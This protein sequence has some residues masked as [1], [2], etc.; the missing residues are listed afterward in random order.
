M[1]V[2][3]INLFNKFIVA[4]IS[5]GILPLLFISFYSG[6]LFRR[7]TYTLI[8]DNYQQAALYGVRNLD[9]LIEKYNTISKLL[10]SYN[11]DKN[12]II[13]RA[14]G[15]GLARVLNDTKAD[16]PGQIK[17]HNDIIS[18]LYLIH[19]SDTYITNVVFA[20][21]DGTYYA[22]GQNNRPF[23]DE[24]VFLNSMN[25]KQIPLKANQL[26]VIPTHQDNYF[27]KSNNQVFTIG[28]NYIDL[29]YHLGVDRIIG[30]LYIDINIKCIDDIF[31]QLDIYHSGSIA[32]FDS[33][34]NL[35]YGNLIYYNHLINGSGS[36]EITQHCDNIPWRIVLT[37]DIERA[38]HNVVSI[39]RWISI[40]V[41]LVLTALLL[42]SV[43]YS[44][45]FSNPI[46][47]LLEGMKKV[48]AGDFTIHVKIKAHDEIGEL[49]EGFYQMTARLKSYIQTS[50]LAQIRQKEAELS[51]LKAKIK[52][53]FLYNS[54]ELIR[55][56]AI[57]HND[58]ST[59]ELVFLLAGQIRAS[60]EHLNET[61]NLSQELDMIRGYFA[62]IDLRYNHNIAWDISCDPSLNRVRVLSLMLQPIIE[63]AVIHGIKPRG[64]GH[65]RI[66]IEKQGDNLII[67]VTDD[68][69]GMDEEMVKKIKMHLQKEYREEDR[70]EDSIGLKNVHDRLRYKYGASYGV[71][72]FSV[73]ESGTTIIIT[74]PFIQS[75]GS[76]V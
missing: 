23:A 65:I 34:N 56:N 3:R 54:L 10:Y 28:R 72:I 48:E 69:V 40:I 51:S 1:G 17:R 59:A 55:M 68:G 49:A 29:S 76:D 19:T 73:P 50:F 70:D 43:F 74:L 9:S 4:F 36:L 27:Q 30:T 7:E 39:I 14:D 41:V 37:A 63:N 61:V 31:K 53:H 47:N 35:I 42:V 62:F 26:R 25:K 45:L 58:E 60:I 5:V 16:K 15:Q 2:I 46:R 33:G 22:F 13:R 21:I 75:E 57:T 44:K 32:I 38:M 52:P 24:N 12:N 71:S 64:R 66:S 18:F 8:Q 6:Y 67:K 20:S 11:L